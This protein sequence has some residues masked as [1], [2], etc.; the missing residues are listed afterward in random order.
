MEKSIFVL[1][2]IMVILLKVL[3]VDLS[4][5][6]FLSEFESSEEE[7]GQTCDPVE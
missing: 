6:D 7:Y 4:L 1:C 3:Q 5:F 2:D